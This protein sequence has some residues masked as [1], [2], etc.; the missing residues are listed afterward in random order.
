[1]LLVVT[2][3][4]AFA[5]VMVL[6]ITL[7]WKRYGRS[8]SETGIPE[9]QLTVLYPALSGPHGTIQGP[10]IVGS[11]GLRFLHLGVAGQTHGLSSR[12]PIRRD[13]TDEKFR[14]R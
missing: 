1:M 6:A 11:S 8:R 5:L 9:Y 4:Y 7:S 12:V 3:E 13:S 10:V 2:D 14:D